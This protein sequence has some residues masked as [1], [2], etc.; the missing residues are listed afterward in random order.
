MTT[1]LCYGDSNTWGHDPA[2]GERLPGGKRWPG[3]LRRLLPGCEIV[4]EGL[5]GRTT[6]LDDPFEE[7]RNGLA[8]LLPCLLSH[9]PIDLVVLMLGTNDSKTIFPLDAAGIA[10]AAERLVTVVRRSLCGPGSRSPQVLLV[11]PPPVT[12]PG[13]LQRIWGF[14]AGSVERARELPRYYRAAAEHLGC[15]FL[16]GS[17][18]AAVSPADGVHLDASAHEALGSAIAESVRAALGLRGT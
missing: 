16:D 4:E 7:G 3:V 5:P 12:D 1:I 15:G 17:A 11:A 14:S 8:Y 10:A 9:A 2:S 18:V 13:P 6:I